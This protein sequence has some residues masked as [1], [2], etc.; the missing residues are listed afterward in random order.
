MEQILI[1]GK[2]NR[3]ISSLTAFEALSPERFG[4]LQ[5]FNQVPNGFMFVVGVHKYKKNARNTFLRCGKDLLFMQ[6]F[7]PHSENKAY[8]NR[9][10]GQLYSLYEP[11]ESEQYEDD[12]VF[13]ESSVYQKDGAHVTLILADGECRNRRCVAEMFATI[14]RQRELLDFAPNNSLPRVYKVT[15]EKKSCGYFLKDRT[16]YVFATPVGIPDA[17]SGEI[18]KAWLFCDINCGAPAI[19]PI[20]REAFQALDCDEGDKISIFTMRNDVL[21]YEAD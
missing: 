15:F 6:N 9:G 20:E 5:R 19:I 18:T 13:S 16:Y 14:R 8:A 17:Q 12:I 21:V 1:G 3:T 4:L 7:L 2:K 11:A 10:Y